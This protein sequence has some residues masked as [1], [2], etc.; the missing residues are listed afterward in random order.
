[1]R[2]TFRDIATEA[3]PPRKEPVRSAAEVWYGQCIGG[4][5]AMSHIVVSESTFERC[6]TNSNYSHCIYTTGR[7]RTFMNNRFRGCG[8]PF[9]VGAGRDPF[10][11]VTIVGNTVEGSVASPWRT[12]APRYPYVTNFS[13]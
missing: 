4:G 3:F 11:S 13:A 10:G 6:C 8:S 2:C 7:S 1:T 5:S 9:A 12:G